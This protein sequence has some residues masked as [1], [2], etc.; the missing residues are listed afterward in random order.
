MA[1]S[2]PRVS[3]RTTG[4]DGTVF[5]IEPELFFPPLIVVLVIVL[6]CFVYYGYQADEEME[7]RRRLKQLSHPIPI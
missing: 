5:G 6:C 3:T 1:R 2:V 4:G 7:R